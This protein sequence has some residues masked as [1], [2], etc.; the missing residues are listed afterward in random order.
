M[1]SENILAINVPNILSIGIMGGVFFLVVGLV[2]K[3]VSQR[4]GS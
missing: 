2:M 1:N 3:A 4:K